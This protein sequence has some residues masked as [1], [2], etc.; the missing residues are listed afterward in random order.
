MDELF[1]AIN[2]HG[3][4]VFW[5]CP[6]GCRDFVDWNEDKTEAVCR[7]CGAKSTDKTAPNKSLNSD[8]Q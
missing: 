1:D 6:N 4:F 8:P 2:K 5:V 7:Q 3:S